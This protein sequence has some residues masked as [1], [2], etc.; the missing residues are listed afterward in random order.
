MLMQLGCSKAVSSLH[1]CVYT[2]P[3]SEHQ[4]LMLRRQLYIKFTQV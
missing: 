3:E 4:A 1:A 2:V